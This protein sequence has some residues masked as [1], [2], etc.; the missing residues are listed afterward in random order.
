[1]S[2]QKDSLTNH[3]VLNG[4]SIDTESETTAGPYTNTRRGFIGLAAAGIAGAGLASTT[5]AASA[6]DYEGE[7][8]NVV[9]VVDAGADN[10]G[11]TSITPV[12]EDNRSDNTL[13]YFPPGDY[14]MDSQFRFTNFEKFGVVGNDATLIPGD[15]WDYNGSQTRMFRL[16]TSGR[17]GGHVRFENFDIDQTA[18]DTG[19]RVIDTYASKRLEVRNIRI[20]G[21]H[22]SG[23]SGPGH[24]N[25]TEPSATGIV[26]RFRAP[27]GGAWVDNTP[28]AGNHWRGPIGIEANQNRGTLTFRRCWLGGFPDNGLY[29]SGGSGKIIV[30]GGVYRNSNGANVRVGGNGSEVNWPTIEVN[31][32]REQDGSQRGIRLENGDGMSVNGAAIRITSPMPTSRAISVM[33]SCDG[34]T[35]SDTKI[36]MSGDK[37]NHGIVISQAAGTVLVEETDIEHN[38]AGGYSIW[39]RDTDSTE[40]VHCRRVSISGEVGDAS[41]FR[42][43]IRCERDN[44][45]FSNCEVDTRGRDG[46]RRNAFVSTA[47]NTTLY[48]NT[49]RAERFPYIELGSNNLIHYCDFESYQSGENAVCLYDVADDIE[50]RYNRLVNGIQD[51]GASNI[52]EFRTT[53][54]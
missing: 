50:F 25:L 48:R 13:F 16:G 11:N 4:E 2:N 38:T 28:H 53:L 6:T 8:D 36:E 30:D 10:S 52:T 51:R 35:I 33:N 27:D 31:S 20:Y 12:L 43:A 18:P 46:V 26:E 42:D 15:Y 39:V 40:R 17:P 49:F 45:R 34:A 3:E 32:T 23:T 37:I 54:E 29:A 7:Y 1:M 47:A 24:F 14:L 44:S 22:D 19:I 21:E 5:A 9:N 41:G